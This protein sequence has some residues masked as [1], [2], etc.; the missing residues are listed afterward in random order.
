M[1]SAFGDNG[2]GVYVP[3]M[4]HARICEQNGRVTDVCD[5][6]FTEVAPWQMYQALSPYFGPG[7]YDLI[8]KNCNC[9]S[10][11]ALFY[12]LGDRLEYKYRAVERLGKAGQSRFGLM[13][14]LNKMG[15]KYQENPSAAGFKNDEVVR[16]LSEVYGIPYVEPYKRRGRCCG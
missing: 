8:R 4:S 10:D 13:N 5:M 15:M 14:M 11:C 7:T 6:G 12:L 9:F 1:G 16:H 3:L 2:V